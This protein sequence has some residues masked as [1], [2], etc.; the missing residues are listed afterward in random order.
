MDAPKRSPNR[1]LLII[2]GAAAILACGCCSFFAILSA[3]TPESIDT[4]SNPVVS[5]LGQAASPVAQ[6]EIRA[7]PTPAPARPTATLVLGTARENPVPVGSEVTAGSYK[8]Q[9]MTATRPAT[10]LVMAAN[11]FNTEP[12]TGKEYVLVEVAVTCGTDECS[13]SPLDFQMIGSAGIIYEAEL[14]VT[15]VDNTLEVTE[16]LNGATVI[17]KLFFIVQQGET[18]LILKYDQLFDFQ[19]E[20]Y[21]AVP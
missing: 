12:D 10:D 14:F 1:T 21:L 18:G 11:M 2:G 15:G 8:L 20:I 9:V 6:E 5:T 13:V 16:F 3:L 19:S 17:G 4:A 7:T